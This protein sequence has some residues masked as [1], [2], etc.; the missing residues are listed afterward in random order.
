MLGGGPRAFTKYEAGSVKPAAA[1]VTLLR[2]LDHFPPTLR[3]LQAIKSRPMTPMPEQASPF[4]ITGKDV[5]LLSADQWPRFLR[6]LL[7]AEAHAHGLP[8]DGIHVASDVSAPDGG[9]DGRIEWQGGKERTP[10]LPC[11]ITQFQLKSGPLRPAEAGRDV[12]RGPQQLKPLIRSVLQAGGHYRMLCGHN[13]TQQA[14]ESRE[15]SIR[16][17]AQGTE[18]SID[19]HQ[20]S[21]WDASQVADWANEHPA[22]AAWVGERTPRAVGPFRSWEHW[23]NHRDHA[24]AWVQDDRLPELR[25]RLRETAL[26]P[27]RVLRVVGLLGIGKS[28]LILEGLHHCAVSDFVLYANEEDADPKEVRDVVERLASAGA[29]AVVVV[30]R[31][32]PETH[33]SLAGQVSRSSSR[34]SLV[35]L[36]DEIPETKLDETTIRIDWAKDAVVEAI[37]DERLPGLPPEDRRRLAHLSEG[38]PRIAT[39]VADAW[40]SGTPVA[41]F[42]QDDL[43]DAY[44][45][46]RRVHRE[47]TLKSAMLVAAFGLIA[48]E[49]EAGQ[50]DEVASFR[51][52]LTVD[53]LR[54]GVD[55]LVQR[56]VAR[57]RGRLRSLQPRPIAMRLAERQ[58]REWTKSQWERALT[59]G[60]ALNAKAARVLALLNTTDIA[61]KVVRHVC[62]PSGP[63]SGKNALSGP[64]QA[65]VVATLSE[66]APADVLDVLERALN[67]V[68]DPFQ[69]ADDVLRHVVRG[70]ERIAFHDDAATFGTA[71][72]LLLRLAAADTGNFAKPMLLLFEQLRET[73]DANTK[74]AL[75]DEILAA[76]SNNASGE[77]VRLFRAHRVDVDT[78]SALFDQRLENSDPTKSNVLTEAC[79]AATETEHFA[80]KAAGVF[81][82]LFRT[83][84]GNT[85]VDGNTRLALFDQLWNTANAIKKGVMIDALA[86]AL[87]P[88]TIRF[89]GAETQGARPA[90]SPWFPSARN[91]Q[92]KYVEGCLCRL[93]KVAG[94][95]GA[96]T[97]LAQR[98]QSRLGPQM[99]TLLRRGYMNAVERTVRQVAPVVGDWPAAATSVGE[100]LEYDAES[101]GQQTTDRVRG[102]LATLQPKSLEARIRLLVKQM[103]WDFALGEKLDHDERSQRQKSALRDLV[104]ELARAPCVLADALPG[105]SRGEQSQGGLFGE[106]LGERVDVFPPK[107]WLDRVDQA[108]NE[109]PEG[110]RNRNAPRDFREFL[111]RVDKLEGKRNLG[112]L[113]GYYVGTA[114]ARPDMA[115]ALKQRLAESATLTPALPL[116]CARLGIVRADIDLVIAALRRGR[117]PSHRLSVW[118]DALRPLPPSQV[119]PLLDALL[120]RPDSDALDVAIGLTC[121]F[122]RGRP[123]ALEDLRPQVRMCVQNHAAERGATVRAPSYDFEELVDWLLS[124]GRE[125]SDACATALD[126]AKLL[127]ATG[128]NVPTSI[129]CRLLSGF[130]EVAWPYLGAAITKDPEQAWLLRLVLGPSLGEMPILSLPEA[131]LLAW[132]HAH[133]DQA[134]AFAATVVPVLKEDQGRLTLHPTLRRLI[135]EFGDRPDVREGIES[136]IGTYRW[137]GSRTKYYKQYVEPIRGLTAHPIPAVRSW[138]GRMAAK[139]QEAIEHVH[140]QDEELHAER[141]I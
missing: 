24:G 95:S 82:R 49:G 39:G 93:A 92:G 5:A 37:I 13:Y 120:A 25:E 51:H 15:R 7:N 104:D 106:M 115:A 40:R 131:T 113:C 56:G 55:S 11:R 127:V 10:F 12:L 91:V 107:T 41:H 125:D 126:L 22:V 36:D 38:F 1:V 129:T 8:R 138:A 31:C 52:D 76:T 42:A 87:E 105:L 102:L 35:T 117:L 135:D 111:D 94:G 23:R 116:V 114:K 50:L 58:W 20:I 103:P 64:R 141:D 61:E 90:L 109:A 45:P 53:D 16:A 80:D 72:E 101:A 62:R 133:P 83:Y 112:F 17:A 6:R 29:W 59:G 134:P 110:G 81:V 100:F 121:F 3:H 63:L 70:L 89:V 128:T 26:N 30:N 65:E 68:G 85:E 54:I 21:F 98:A 99:R 43:V 44:V 46:G 48:V 34:L 122:S 66:V 57:R 60:H 97:A 140:D 79:M 74:K 124:K 75:I 33:R 136:N 88:T 118:G 130:P 77:F 119:A 86:E 69:V 137:V 19:D 132:C 27:Q 78:T 28:R 71:A 32:S 4:Q 14:K 96:D 108:A 9:E 18:L 67:A 47:A 2:L 73:A 139:L 84:G 123:E